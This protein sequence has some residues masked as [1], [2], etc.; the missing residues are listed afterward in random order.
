MPVGNQRVVN[1][2]LAAI[3][4]VRPIE[5]IKPPGVD[6]RTNP[7]MPMPG[8]KQMHKI[9]NDIVPKNV[10]LKPLPKPNKNLP[11][12]KLLIK[13]AKDREKKKEKKEI[14]SRIDYETVEK[15]LEDI[16]RDLL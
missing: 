4:I 2:K 11:G 16:M 8:M 13:L 14:E 15:V 7:P 3:S 1:K 10:I 12:T 9:N 6:P 5:V